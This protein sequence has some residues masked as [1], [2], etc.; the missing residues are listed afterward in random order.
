LDQE[1]SVTDHTHPELRS[2]ETVRVLERGLQIIRAFL[3]ANEWLTNKT[4]SELLNVPKPTVSRITAKLTDLG[5]LE[6]SDDTGRYRLSTGVVAL[7]FLAATNINIRALA[8]RPLQEFADREGVIVILGR[9]D[10]LSMVCDEVCHSN[11][12][13]LTLRIGVDSRL[14]LQN[15]PL[16]LALLASM[17]HQERDGVMKEMK[18]NNPMAW[19]LLK[20]S[21]DGLAEQV[22]VDGFCRSVGVPE[23][24]IN[25]IGTPIDVPDHP[26]DFALA[27]AGPAFMLPPARLDALGKRMLKM[28]EALEHELRL[29]SISANRTEAKTA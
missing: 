9:K 13:L 16:G 19:K 11:K 25:G 26:K 28:K 23:S 12:T 17:P 8:K 18:L 29:H 7:G 6:Y 21:L 22:R 1:I 2:T 24:T 20:A 14:E 15:S 10:R 5:Y 4:L 3:P 27:C